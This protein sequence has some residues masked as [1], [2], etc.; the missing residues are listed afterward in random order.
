MI[1][2]KLG[3]TGYHVFPVAYGGI[4]SMNDGNEASDNYVSWAFEKGVNYFDIAPSYGDAQEKLGK[5]LIP[6]RKEI[7]L[8]CK[9]AVRDY[10][11]AKIEFEN[12]LRLLH[13][14]YFD[15]Y[16]L[17]A[18][19]SEEEVTRA[20]SKSG[21]MELLFWAKEKGYIRKLGIT[22]HSEPAALKAI[23][24][25]NFDTVLFPLN[26]HLHLSKNFGTEI[27]TEAKKRG[28]GILAMKQLIE[29]SWLES[30]SELHERFN[31]SWCKPIDPDNIKLR[32]NAIKYTL[33]LG[34]DIIIPPG[35]FFNFSYAVDNIEK[36]IKEPL[37]EKDLN[38]LKEECSRV[39][40]HPFF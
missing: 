26:W 20:F 11:G 15:V 5:S 25:F 2:N 39:C 33:S 37:C 14:D 8:A 28:M 12:S 3:N 36:C 10:E 16:Q 19:S 18:L 22:A 1:K 40:D 35:D 4:I 38:Y 6:Y 32:N 7:Y 27:V 29:R 30:D 24:N 34:A 13:T 9:T 23:E 21:V 17:H 31:K